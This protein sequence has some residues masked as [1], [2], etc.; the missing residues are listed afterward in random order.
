MRRRRARR[1]SAASSTRSF[2]ADGDPRVRL[3]RT[4]GRVGQHLPALYVGHDRRSQGGGLQPSRRLPRRARQ[5]A[6][7]QARPREP[8]PVDAADVPLLGLDLHVGGHRGRG[9]ARVPAQ[10][11]AKRIFDAIAEHRVTHMCG[12]PIVLNMLVHAPADAKRPLPC[13]PRWRPVVRHR[14]R[15]SSSAWR[16]WASRC[17]TCT[18]P[19][20]ATGRRP[21]ARRCRNGPDLPTGERYAADGAPGHSQSADRAR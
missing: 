10:G 1:A 12:A 2:I 20:R 3:Q 17:C 4:R 16:Q 6:D 5:R 14:R 18:A 9:Y 11:G 15:S 19:R 8:L 21:T 13:V 7:L